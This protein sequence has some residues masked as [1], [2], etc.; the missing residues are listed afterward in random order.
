MAKVELRKLEQHRNS[1][2]LSNYRKEKQV[3]K[4]PKVER[5]ACLEMK[6]WCFPMAFLVCEAKGA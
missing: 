2:E 1:L 6:T 5:T 4:M 3:G